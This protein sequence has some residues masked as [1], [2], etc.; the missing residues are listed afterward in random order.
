MRKTKLSPLSAD[1]YT[2]ADFLKPKS[3]IPVMTNRW[4]ALLVFLI[5]LGVYIST[6][7][8]SLSFWDAGEYITCSSILGIPHPP[9]NP[10]YIL[11]GRFLS[12]VGFGLPH[13]LIVNAMSAILSALAV[14]FTYLFT[15]KLVSMFE[16]NSTYILLAGALAA[17]YTAF[18]YTFWMNSVEAEVYA[19]LAITINSIMWL[20]LVWVEKSKDFSHQH[21]LLLIVYIFFLGFGIHQTSL[22]IAPA[23]LF[24]ALYPLIRDNS[25]T[26][27][28][29]TRAIL[30]SIALLVLYSIFS[31]LSREYQIPDLAKYVVGVGMVGMMYFHLRHKFCNRIW[32]LALFFI[33][34]GVST[35]LFLWF[36]AANRPFI[37]EGHPHNL[38]LFTNYILRRQ[39]GVVSFMERRVAGFES[40]NIISWI[41]SLWYQ[42]NHH[43]LRYFH[44]QFFNAETLAK[45]F[46]TGQGLF[47]AISF[48]IVSILGL[49]GMA[50]QL[51]KNKHS[52]AYLLAFFFMAS[53]AMVF[54]MNLSDAEVRDRDYFFVTAYN[55]WAIWLAIGSLGLLRAFDKQKALKALALVIVLALPLINLVSQYHVHDRKGEFIA[56]DYGLNLLNGLEE[57]AIIITNGDNDT[58]PL[59]YA[60]A[61]YDPHSIEHIYPATDVSP[62]DSTRALLARAA[63]YKAEQCKGVRT[64]V[65]IANLSLLN[66]PWYIR[67]LRDLEG[68][69]INIPDKQIE[70]LEYIAYKNR[71][72]HQKDT[73]IKIKTPAGDDYIEAQFKKGEQLTVKDL[74]IIQIVKDNFGKRPIYFAVTVASNV[75][76]GNYLVNEGMVEKLVPHK[77][78]R[79]LNLERTE[80][81]LENVYSFRSIFDDDVYKDKNILRLLNNYGAAYFRV[82]NYYND[83][84]DYAKATKLLNQGMKYAQDKSQ[85]VPIVA[86]LLVRQGKDEEAIEMMRATIEENPDNPEMYLRMALLLADIER[87]AEAFELLESAMELDPHNPNYPLYI[88]QMTYT[89]KI[90]DEGIATLARLGEKFPHAIKIPVFIK[91]LIAR[92]K[93]AN[94]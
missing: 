62:T 22:Q 85:F 56:L 76:F 55:I 87:P 72:Q 9:G 33:L 36:R 67:Q 11:I 80:N 27:K 49:G 7:A 54:V 35:H 73:N 61:V 47:S 45:W 34:I 91:E 53:F 69:E 12:I 92:Q 44:W 50:Y 19:G 78:L 28:F 88:Y 66:T 8:P 10:F 14:M 86:D 20:I 29:W 25:K 82:S 48:F 57:N 94:K 81:N 38:E 24:V 13:A 42:F 79:S 4:A 84:G 15:V 65:S 70:M 41:S 1:V 68:I 23:V 46:G 71:F 58:F 16:K 30:Y 21:L 31:P 77:K 83:A 3:I 26:K 90:F 32:L 17:F 60:Q 40:T 64:D 63:A 74:A 59:W 2:T 51:K 6:I 37:N 18:S 43:F 75:G 39:Y 93:N 5:S 89:Y 52:F